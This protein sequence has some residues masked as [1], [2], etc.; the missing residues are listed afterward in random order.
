MC[1]RRL[2]CGCLLASALLGIPRI[3]NALNPI[4][5]SNGGFELPNIFPSGQVGQDNNIPG[6]VPDLTYVGGAG[7]WNFAGS[8]YGYF[9]PTTAPE[10]QQVLWLGYFSG[11]G[12]VTQTFPTVLAA[13]ATYEVTGYAGNPAGL[14]VPWSVSLSA[15]D[16]TTSTLL[17]QISGS[18]PGGTL[19][20]FMLSFDS[21]GTP[22]AGQNLQITLYSDGVQTVFDD[23]HFAT[24]V[25]VVPGDIDGNGDVSLVDYGILTSHW[26]QTVSPGLYGDLNSDGIISIPDFS[27]FKTDYNLFNGG[28]G[29]SLPPVPEPGTLVLLALASPALLLALR[30]RR[31]LAT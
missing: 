4:P 14:V 2:F 13:D 6:W 11:P 5:V 10:G 8:T 1:T 21:T 23:I 26:L 17:A 20:P 25:A 24:S 18:G 15:S 22:Y 28:G 7:I 12:L 31:N 3:A 30:C 19:D 27:I 16:G 29:G 9:N